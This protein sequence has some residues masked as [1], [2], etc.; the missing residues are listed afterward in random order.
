[1][2]VLII[3]LLTFF[4]IFFILIYY[5]TTVIALNLD[6][7]LLL[8]VQEVLLIFFRYAFFI[9]M[10]RNSWTFSNIYVFVWGKNLILHPYSLRLLK[11]F[12]QKKLHG[13]SSVILATFYILF[14]INLHLLNKKKC[15]HIQYQKMYKGIYQ[16]E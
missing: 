3:M 2:C 13:G 4:F 10:N 1:M 12:I 15:V 9:E 8:Y 7:Q 6:P 14:Y 16:H 11:I 5:S